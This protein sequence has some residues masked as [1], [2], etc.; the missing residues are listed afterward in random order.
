MKI[1][2]AVENLPLA[3]DGE[4]ME[5]SK[6]MTDAEGEAAHTPHALSLVGRGCCRHIVRVRRACSQI[7]LIR[8]PC[9]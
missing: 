4:S 2:N 5:V 9:S 6:M 7:L 3:T 8:F 1:V